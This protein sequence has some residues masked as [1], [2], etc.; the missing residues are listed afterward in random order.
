MSVDQTC[1]Q[2]CHASAS[3]ERYIIRGMRPSST[4]CILRAKPNKKWTRGRVMRPSSTGCVIQARDES[5]KFLKR[6]AR[7][8]ASCRFSTSFPASCVW[9]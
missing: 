7:F 8:P 3:L 6:L 1:F 9:F 2:I 4:G 5:G